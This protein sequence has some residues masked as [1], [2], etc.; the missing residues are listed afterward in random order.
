MVLTVPSSHL[1]QE[2]CKSY[3]ISIYQRALDWARVAAATQHTAVWVGLGGEE[4]EQTWPPQN[5]HWLV[6]FHHLLWGSW[7]TTAQITSLARESFYFSFLPFLNLWT[8]CSILR[9]CWWGSG[10]RRTFIYSSITPPHPHK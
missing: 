10:I 9:W 4:I 3:P 8:T 6:R 1:K 7:R 2:E 5:V